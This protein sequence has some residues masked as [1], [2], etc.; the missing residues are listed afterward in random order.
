M[1]TDGVE[2]GEQGSMTYA[3]ENAAVHGFL[4]SILGVCRN[5]PAW[6]KSSGFG[7]NPRDFSF[8]IHQ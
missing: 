8:L 6:L 4:P 3:F 7:R 5:D 2:T 1:G